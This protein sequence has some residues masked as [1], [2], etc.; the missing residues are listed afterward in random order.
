MI[1][2]YRRE[3]WLVDL[4]LRKK[5]SAVFS[6]ISSTDCSLRSND[7]TFIYCLFY[8][9]PHLPT[10]FPPNKG[11]PIVVV[12]EIERIFFVLNSKLVFSVISPSITSFHNSMLAV[13]FNFHRDTQHSFGSPASL[14]ALESIYHSLFLDQFCS[15]AD[16][17]QFLSF[18]IHC[19]GALKLSPGPNFRII[20]G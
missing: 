7:V 20:V 2:P 5:R 19:F 14:K 15:P 18:K 13:S 17:L 10:N 12:P 11:S 1:L 9:W 8:T 6:H 4:V 3:S 16:Q